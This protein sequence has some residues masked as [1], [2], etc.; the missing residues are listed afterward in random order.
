MHNR[1]M[2]SRVLGRSEKKK[3]FK[4]L[5]CGHDVVSTTQRGAEVGC[6]HCRL[7]ILDELRG[8]IELPEL[9]L[10]PEGTNIN[11]TRKVLRKIANE[12]QYTR[13]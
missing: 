11:Y 10:V 2:K 9:R 7:M 5:N 1:V 12:K 13:R 6:Y 4:V 8:T 3:G